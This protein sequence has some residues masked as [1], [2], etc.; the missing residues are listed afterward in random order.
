MKKI[1]TVYF[2][3]VSATFVFGELPTYKVK[4]IS[5][6]YDDGRLNDE[7]KQPLVEL[8]AVD[9]NFLDAVLSVALEEPVDLDSITW[10]KRAN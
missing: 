3:L 10:P 4:L 8:V 7:D 6:L 1:I 5:K 9:D 2:L